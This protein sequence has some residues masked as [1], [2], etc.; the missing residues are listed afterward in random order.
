[1][2]KQN[3][4]GIRNSLPKNEVSAKNGSHKK[5]ASYFEH[6]R[7]IVAILCAFTLL[8]ILSIGVYT[9]G[10]MR[11]T[12]NENMSEIISKGTHLALTYLDSLSSFWKKTSPRT[13]PDIDYALFGYNIMRGYPLAIGH[14]PG[15]TRPIFQSD[16]S[17]RIMT[18]DDRFYVPHGLVIV[19]DVSC[20]TS[21][22]S[23]IIQ[24]QYQLTK[25]LSASASVSGGGWGASFAASADYKKKSSE[26]SSKEAVYV[27][28]KA[29]CDYYMSM[30]DEMQP[31]SLSKSFLMMARTIKKQSDVFKLLDYYGTHYLKQ[32]TFGARLVYENKMTK[33]SFKTFSESSYSVTASAGY[34]GIVRVE[35]SGSLSKAEKTQASLFRSSVE[36]STISVGAPPPPDGSTN[37]WASAVKENPVPTKFYMADIQDLFTQKFM[38]GSG[39]DYEAAY[40]LISNSKKAY[41]EYLQKKGDVDSCKSIEGYSKFRG[42][43]LGGAKAFSKFHADERSCVKSCMQESKCIALNYNKGE[44]LLFGEGDYV[45][46]ASKGVMFLFIDRLNLNDGRLKLENARISAPTRAVYENIH[47]KGCEEKCRQDKKCI[48]FTTNRGKR[49][50]KLYQQLSI[51]DDS[52][53]FRPAEGGVTVE[54]QTVKYTNIAQSNSSL[55]RFN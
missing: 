28:S 41:C 20:V 34:S 8:V 5:R 1:M 48:A 9:L 50:C 42:M 4:E 24:D 49:N 22:S 14:D 6:L 39:F 31:P 46:E 33:S 37:R 45:V 7:Y 26:V 51:T 19:P 35:G 21:F 10:S 15:L 29:E 40:Q 13:F 54:F 52:I 3:E 43:V 2:L 55:S 11:S 18:S 30:I 36:T 38:G 23:S 25:S 32:V 17:G 47:H 27:N 44:C 53:K 16:Y 12:S